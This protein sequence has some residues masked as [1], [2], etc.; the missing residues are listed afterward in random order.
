MMTYCKNLTQKDVTWWHSDAFDHPDYEFIC[1]L[2]GKR[3]NSRFSCCS[4]KRC[5]NYEPKEP[6]CIK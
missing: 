1:K 6:D 4:D 2:T 3:V 5:E